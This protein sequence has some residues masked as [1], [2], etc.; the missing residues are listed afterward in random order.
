M[1]ES[2]TEQKKRCQ[3]EAQVKQEQQEHA[4]KEP[5]EQMKQALRQ[6]A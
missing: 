5:W 6:L 2:K 1:W 3:P 4:K